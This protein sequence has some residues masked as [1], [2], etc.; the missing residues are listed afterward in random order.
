MPDVSPSDRTE[1]AELFGRSAESAVLRSFVERALTRDD[2]LLMTGEPGVGKSVLLE[3]AARHAEASGATV[4]RAAGV[5]FEAEVGFAGLHQLLLP[6]LDDVDALAGPH[7]RALDVALGLGC[8]SSP[9]P[10]LVS[11]AVLALVRRGAQSRPVL[12]VVD[13]LPWLDRSSVRVLGFVARRVHRSRIGFL[14]AART[15]SDSALLQVGLPQLEVPPLDADAAADLLQ[16]RFPLLDPRIRER[17]LSASAGNPLALLE[18]PAVMTEAQRTGSAPLPPALTLSGQLRRVFV[19]QLAGLPATTRWLLLLASLEGTGDLRTLRAA[20]ADDRWLDDLAPAERARLVRI[21]LSGQRVV[22]GHPLIGSAAVEISSSGEIRRAHGALA[23]VL[24]DRPEECAWHLAEAVVGSDARAADL[25]ETAAQRAR[26]RGDPVRAVQTLLQAAGLTPNGPDRARRLAAAASVAADTTGELRTVP[27]LLREARTAD[28]G[29]AASLEVAVASAH[30]LLNGDGDV[31]T[32]HLVLARA[33][34]HAV[35]DGSPADVVEDALYSLMTVCHFGGREEL[36]RP[37]EW[38]LTA[39]GPDVPPVLSVSSSLFADPVR[40]TAAALE[41]LDELLASVDAAVDPTFVVRVGMAAWYADRL[42]D[43]RRA[44]RRVVRDGRQGGA[45]AAAVKGLVLLCHDALDAGRWDEA[46]GTAEE[47]IAWGDRLGYRLITRYGV[48]CSALVAAARGDGETAQVVSDDLVAWSLPRG[49]HLFEDFAH[50]VRGL[51]ALGRGDFQEAYRQLTAVS[52]VGG[53]APCGPVA[54]R[55]VMDLVE[56]AVRTGRS[57]E[58]AAHVA[59][60]GRARV[61]AGRPRLG[62]LLAGSAALVAS[63]E[64]AAGR[65]E[66]A[67]AVPGADRYPFERARVQ[68]AFGEHLRRTRATNAS[69]VQLAAALETFRD[70]GSRPW[71]ER[72]WNELRA[73]GLTHR[74][75]TVER[76]T[77]ALTSQEYQIAMLAASG[78]SNKQIGSRLY[79][80]PRTVGAHLYRVFPKL[81]ISSR[82]ALRDALNGTA[83]EIVEMPRSAG[84]R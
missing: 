82:A 15:G 7:R 30:H 6:L 67:L 48:Y 36:W 76:G 14:A 27:R 39:L 46:V 81:G 42:G 4:L 28:P 26:R 58:A 84:A 16:A 78:L 55:V 21:D 47:G 37:V 31:G 52:P 43:C 71:A 79:L 45:A 57:A 50:H 44:L 68:L 69:R 9:S 83:P 61:F 35:E 22:L 24:V 20:A 74:S 34:E 60:V 54:L 63:G 5:E 25:L 41:W 72:A 49:I 2:V 23:S 10:L 32:A 8:G 17:V 19:Q 12:I 64:E 13:D 40:A 77:G 51:A 3:T 38:A 73:T 53:P 59:A 11:A 80:S 75:A 29:T 56:A 70:L 1:G 18:L 62:L 33:V 66:R 65:F